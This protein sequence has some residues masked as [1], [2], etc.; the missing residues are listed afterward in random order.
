MVEKN[1]KDMSADEF[2]SLCQ[3]LH[4]GNLIELD[5]V[6]VHSTSENLDKI[7][8]TVV[9]LLDKYSNFLLLKKEQDIKMNTYAG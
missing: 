4:K 6:L 1:L 8:E 3:N 7:K 9:F 2:T 5:G